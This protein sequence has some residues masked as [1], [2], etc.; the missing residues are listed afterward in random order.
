MLLAASERAYDYL[1]ALFRLSC[2]DSLG[3]RRGQLRG[4]LAYASLNVNA[5]KNKNKN[6]FC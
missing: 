3:S 4:K 6:K 2:L 1:H 5:L